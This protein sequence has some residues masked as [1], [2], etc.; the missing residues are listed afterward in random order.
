MRGYVGGGNV[1]RGSQGVLAGELRRQ[2]ASELVAS[3]VPLPFYLGEG[4]GFYLIFRS[5][6]LRSGV[7]KMQCRF[8]LPL[9]GFALDTK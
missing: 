3:C 4:C 2:E 8:Q 6:S 1:V 9:S 7:S 5:I